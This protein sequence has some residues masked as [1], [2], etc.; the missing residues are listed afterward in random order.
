MEV[1]DAWAQVTNARFMAEPW[2][3]SLLRWTR[4]DRTG[5]Y[6]IDETIA[7]MDAGGVAR[8]LQCA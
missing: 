2:L 6:G 3:E 7:A 4:L 5:E 1:I 8:S